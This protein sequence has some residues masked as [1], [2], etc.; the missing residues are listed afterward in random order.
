LPNI[1]YASGVSAVMIGLFLTLAM[2]ETNKKKSLIHFLIAI[3]AVTTLFVSLSN[4]GF[5]SMLLILVL[6]VALLFKATDK[7]RATNIL[8]SFIIIS[9]AL[10]FTLSNYNS[11]VWDE[12][13]GIFVAKNPF[14]VASQV[15]TVSN[16]DTSTKTELQSEYLPNLPDI[17]LGAG[18]GRL[19][20]WK[21][22]LRSIQEKPLFG[23]GLDT[24]TYFLN[25][26]RAEKA[27]NL[28]D[29]FIVI[30]KP[31]NMYLGIAM[32][33]GI[34][35]LIGLL[36]LMGIV[37]IK[38]VLQVYKKNTNWE[39]TVVKAAI[40]F[41]CVAFFFQALFNDSILGVGTIAWILFGLLASLVINQESAS[42]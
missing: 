26:D 34:F 35:T 13:I 39:N 24:Y 5:V 4:S 7:R 40:L 14:E 18:S 11:K 12:S 22:T 9:T 23:Y 19:Y 1:N 20:I 17:N 33:A 25:Q 10:L 37:L 16:I 15:K 36:V 41:A 32:G 6:L 30:D 42:A 29:P 31:H 8:V 21:E 28:G 3:L 2:F 27:A 38:G